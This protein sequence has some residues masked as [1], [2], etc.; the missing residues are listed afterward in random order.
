[1]NAWMSSEQH[2]VVTEIKNGLGHKHEVKCQRTVLQSKDVHDSF[3]ISAALMISQGDRQKQ[4]PTH[5]LLESTDLSAWQRSAESHFEM[6]TCRDHQL[7]AQSPPWRFT[8]DTRPSHHT[9]MLSQIETAKY[10][11]TVTGALV[12]STCSTSLTLT[13]KLS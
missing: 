1:M 9:V 7:K 10:G 13:L 2:C 8:T 4:Q 3:C 6:F 11:R 5:K 12:L